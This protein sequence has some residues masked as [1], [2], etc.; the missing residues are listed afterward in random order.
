MRG[1]AEHLGRRLLSPLAPVVAAVLLVAAWA[2]ANALVKPDPYVVHGGQRYPSEAAGQF[3]SCHDIAFP[4]IR[5]FDTT[6]AMKQ[7]VLR[8][9]PARRQAILHLVPG[10][11][12]QPVSS[13]L[14]VGDPR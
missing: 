6:E 9:F 10:P 7:D 11:T 1:V 8:N 2:A 3:F 13:Q 14:P 12:E 5:C 4:E